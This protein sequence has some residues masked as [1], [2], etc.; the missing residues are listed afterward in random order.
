M[1]ILNTHGNWY[2]HW[3]WYDSHYSHHHN[4]YPAN[5]SVG[6]EEQEVIFYLISK[7]ML[8]TGAWIGIILGIIVLVIIIIAIIVGVIYMVKRNKPNEE[9]ENINAFGSN[10]GT[11]Q[12]PQTA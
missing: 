7:E 11:Q 2:I 9:K 6:K 10:K 8:S 1:S 3:S 4:Y 12:F 5:H